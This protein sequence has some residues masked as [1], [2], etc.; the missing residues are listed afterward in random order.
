M[1]RTVVTGT[2]IDPYLVALRA[3][4]KV[5]GP[6][7][8]DV[9]Q[10]AARAAT[11][12]SREGR[13]DA[14]D[15]VLVTL[16]P[17]GSTD[18][19]Q[20]FHLAESAGRMT[21]HYAIADVAAFVV[22]DDVIDTEAQLRG[23][24]LYLPDGR[25]PLHPPTLS[26]GAASLLPGQD[27]P[28]VLWRIEL[29]RDGEPTQVDVQR[30]VVR[31]RAQLDYAG[32]QHAGGEPFGLLERFGRLRQE[33]ERSRGAVS[34]PELEQQVNGDGA[35]WTL[36][37]RAPLPVED[38]NA[39]LSLL[40]GMAAARM[41]LDAGIGLL[42]T[43]PP[44]D[45]ETV[46]SLRRSAHALA[47]PWPEGTAYADVIRGLD[48]AKP[49]HAALIRLAAVLFRGASYVAF[50]GQPPES[51]THSAVAA[52]YAHATAPLRRL[53]DR[54]VNECCLALHAG[55]PVPEWVR[56]RL[57][58]LPEEMAG[59]DRKAHAV[60]RAVVDLAEALVL[61]SKRDQVMR[62]VVVEPGPKGEIQLQEPAVRARL[63]GD[64]LPLG[65]EVAVKVGELDV[66]RRLVTFV[67]S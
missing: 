25:V 58:L 9:E 43:M 42:R 63:I 36:S 37:Y 7:P 62:G 52:P 49:T 59:A 29:D 20:A 17:P 11:A 45:P 55:A 4:F 39:Q 40:T 46:A 30:A 21:L 1:R 67:L 66:A 8:P 44:P 50:D 34:L 64:D 31:S 33:R 32:L 28:A 6:F 65:E 13:T 22:P 61:Q 48:P 38:W 5:P 3:E 60:D 51:T 18:L 57:P 23:E 53:A 14:T 10:A 12:W 35:N 56:E 47:I 15:L 54:Y 27:R 41:M 16:D 26:E 19:D 2:D 24:T